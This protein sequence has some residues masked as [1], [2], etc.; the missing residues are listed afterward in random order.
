MYCSF[1]IIWQRQKYTSADVIAV[2]VKRTLCLKNSYPL[3]TSG[4]Y[5]Y[6]QRLSFRTLAVINWLFSEPSTVSGRK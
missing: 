5:D 3:L 1:A 4:G 2:W 6:K